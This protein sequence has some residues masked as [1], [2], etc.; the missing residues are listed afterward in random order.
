MENARPMQF[1][2]YPSGSSSDFLESARIWQVARATSAAPSFFD[3]VQIG[4]FGE[5]FSDGG[6]GA[7]NPVQKVWTEARH[8][9]LREGQL[10]EGNLKCLVSIGTGKPSIKPFGKKLQSV[11][12]TLIRI[13]TDTQ[14]TADAFRSAHLEL[15]EDRQYFRFNIE[16][17]LENVGLEDAAQANTI[18]AATR[19]YLDSPELKRQ[20]QVCGRRLVSGRRRRKIP[21]PS[22]PRPPIPCERPSLLSGKTCRIS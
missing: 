14:N 19:Y 13:A 11:G 18:M 2:S 4:R 21:N 20:M 1:K 9:F 8:T 10:L 3:P 17:G 22:G 16:H 6:T 12:Q 7:N 15:E 5:G